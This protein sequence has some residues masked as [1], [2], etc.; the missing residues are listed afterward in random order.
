VVGSHKQSRR[1]S[2]GHRHQNMVE[3]DR[4]VW[5]RSL[6]NYRVMGWVSVSYGGVQGLDI[7]ARVRACSTIEPG[8]IGGSN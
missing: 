7:A 2:A 5:V 3:F 1:L 6:A 8:G 4:R